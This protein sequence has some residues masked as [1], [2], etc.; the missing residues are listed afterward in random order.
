MPDEQNR[1]QELL[2]EFRT[3]FAG[4]NAIL[5]SVL[6]ALLFLL[7][8]AAANL[9]LALWGAL[10]AALILGI[11]RLLRG[12]PWVYALGGLAGVLLAA[13]IVKI[14]G[15]AAGFF[16]PGLISGG[17][18]VLLCFGSVLARRPMVAWTSALARRWPW[19]WYWHPRVRPAY[20]EV[21]LLWGLFFALRLG[22]Q[23]AALQ[24][25]NPQ[26]LGWTQI[27]T[28]WP[29]TL[30]LL[31]ISYL[32]GTRRLKNLAGPSVEEFKTGAAPP[33]QGQQ[34]GF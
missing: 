5:D 17:L 31:I 22:I 32:Y 29:A 20:S 13:T 18:T 27:L 11:F 16:V 12:R 4:R 3:V 23:I 33:W 6:P 2:E 10:T 7:L 8:N 30:G 21:T 25:A 15:N 26:A 19:S 34:R 14:S 1:Q 9:N 24:N 28:G